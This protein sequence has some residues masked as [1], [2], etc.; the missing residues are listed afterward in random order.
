MGAAKRGPPHPR[1]LRGSLLRLPL[2]STS[3]SR[4]RGV[5][6]QGGDLDGRCAFPGF[7]AGD[8]EGAGLVPRADAS[9]A[10]GGVEGGAL[11]GAQGLIARPGIPDARTEDREDEVAG[12]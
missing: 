7:A 1:S 4:R 8:G 10:L 3:G 9:R 6:A 12:D 2:R 5:A 11:G